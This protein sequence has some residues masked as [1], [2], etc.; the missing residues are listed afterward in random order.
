LNVRCSR[1]Q[2]TVRSSLP[3]HKS[4]IHN[5]SRRKNEYERRTSNIERPTS[6][7]R[8]E[9]YS[10]NDPS[11]S[12]LL[13]GSTLDVQRWMFDVRLSRR[14][15]AALFQSINPTIPPISSDFPLVFR[16]HNA[17]KELGGADG[18]PLRGP[19]F[20]PLLFGSTLDVRRSMFDVRV[21]R[22]P[23]TALFQSINLQSTTPHAERMNTN[24]EHP[25]SNA[26]RRTEEAKITAR[27]AHL[28]LLVLFGSTLDV[29][30]S[31]FDVRLSR[32]PCA[33]LFQSINPTIP[34]ISSDFPLVF[35]W[36]NANKEPGGA[37]SSSLPIQHPKF[38]IQSC[39]RP[40][41]VGLRQF[42]PSS[43]ALAPRSKFNVRIPIYH[44]FHLPLRLCD[45][46]R[47]K[48]LHP[49]TFDSSRRCFQSIQS[50]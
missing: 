48:S 24:A 37:A 30:R 45:F 5:T 35:R 50:R 19:S 49:G 9:N 17:N 39:I 32:R 36:Q 2:R 26:Q 21:S 27:T 31:M 8:G 14:P 11:F 4:T 20:S 34:P 22:G 29:R 10:L 18:L 6:N 42:S 38:K 43:L 44:E 12:P 3:I 16:W 28:S 33:A 23:C 41:Q 1:F 46:A 40:C 15:C 13:F 25:T 47:G 7:R